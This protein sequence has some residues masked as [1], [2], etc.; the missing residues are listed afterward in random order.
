MIEGLNAL[1]DEFNTLGSNPSE[2]TLVIRGDSRLVLKQVAGEWK[3]K[4]AALKEL[5]A[6]AQPLL[7]RF[8]DVQLVHQTRAETVRALGH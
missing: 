5:N 3:I 6:E 7:A 4:N 2:A 1:L 8:G